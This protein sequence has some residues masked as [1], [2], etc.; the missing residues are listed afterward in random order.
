V[1]TIGISATTRARQNRR[2]HA[3]ADSIAAA[4]GCTALP[5]SHRLSATAW[6]FP[7][8]AIPHRGC[9][10]C[11]ARRSAL[12]SPHMGM[13]PLSWLPPAQNEG[14]GGFGMLT[15]RHCA[16][17]ARVYSLF[18]TSATEMVQA[19]SARDPACLVVQAKVGEGSTRPSKTT[20]PHNHD[21]RCRRPYLT[22]A[23]ERRGCNLLSP[24]AAPRC[25]RV[26]PHLSAD[27]GRLRPRRPDTLSRARAHPVDEHTPVAAA[28]HAGPI[29]PGRPR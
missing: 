9:A 5:C 27:P 13:P 14:N 12:Y 20:Q 6:G 26:T 28:A 25:P 8:P 2:L 15:G 24:L 16:G 4:L 3:L 23:A 1:A 29:R 21:R 11:A 18:G 22:G 19:F 7:Y 17:E 10:S